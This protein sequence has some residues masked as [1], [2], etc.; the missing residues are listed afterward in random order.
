MFPLTSNYFK[1]LKNGEEHAKSG[2]TNAPIEKPEVTWGTTKAVAP[3]R[4]S[5]VIRTERS[6]TGTSEPW[7]SPSRSPGPQSCRGNS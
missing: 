4:G 1:T 3:K 5:R 2:V 6:E 7:R